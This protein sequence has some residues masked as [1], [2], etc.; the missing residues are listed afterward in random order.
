M[1]AYEV[2]KDPT[3]RE[4]YNLSLKNV[5]FRESE[6][7]FYEDYYQNTDSNKQYKEYY[8]NKW[9]GFKKPDENLQDEY[10]ERKNKNNQEEIVI[11]SILLRFGLI[12]GITSE[13]KEDVDHAGHLQQLQS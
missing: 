7:F 1:K 3:K 2:L 8:S 6:A 9:Y 5:H 12:C 4:I 13:I 11:K 10:F